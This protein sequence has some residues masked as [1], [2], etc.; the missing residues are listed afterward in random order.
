MGFK[1]EVCTVS[2]R[3][4]LCTLVILLV[5]RRSEC[6]SSAGLLGTCLDSWHA[7]TVQHVCSMLTPVKP[8]AQVPPSPLLRPLPPPALLRPL[9]L[10]P[11]PRP[12]QALHQTGLRRNGEKAAPPRAGQCGQTL[13]EKDRGCKDV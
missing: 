8:A 7:L 2:H 3:E 13:E 10:S 9:P 4:Q 11:P 6:K 5:S 1:L 12:A